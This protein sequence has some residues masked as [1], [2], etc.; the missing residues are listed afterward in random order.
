MASGKML[1]SVL[2]FRSLVHRF[3]LMTLPWTRN[4]CRGQSPCMKRTASPGRARLK[5]GGSSSCSHLSSLGDDIG[6]QR[7]LNAAGRSAADG[8]VEEHNGLGHTEQ[9]FDISERESER[10]GVSWT[11]STRS[12][13]MGGRRL[14]RR[15]S[16][17]AAWGQAFGAQRTRRG[18]SKSLDV[19]PRRK[20]AR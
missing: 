7:H 18:T 3:P 11:T 2:L 5:P 15:R 17:G 14:R 10:D 20:G 12:S 8:H 4:E 9:V 13:A 16:E 19:T 1:G 6:A